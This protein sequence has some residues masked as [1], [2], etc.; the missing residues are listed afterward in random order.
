MFP[1]K[2]EELF[3]AAAEHQ[4]F[5]QAATTA[6]N[7]QQQG[8]DAVFAGSLSGPGFNAGQ[9]TLGTLVANYASQAQKSADLAQVLYQTGLAQ[10]DIEK[11]AEKV[12]Q[13]ARSLLSAALHR[14]TI[15]GDKAI[16]SLPICYQIL[17]FLHGISLILDKTCAHQIGCIAVE[18]DDPHGVYLGDDLS[19]TPEQLNAQAFEHIRP[20]VRPLV[21]DPHIAGQDDHTGRKK[22]QAIQVI[23]GKAA[24]IFGD[25]AQAK[26]IVTVVQGVTSSNPDTIVTNVANVSDFYE[27]LNRGKG[28][29]AVVMYDYAAPKGVPSGIHP[30]YAHKAA[31]DYQSYKKAL[32][33]KYPDA[34]LM[35]VG[36]SYGSVLL[37]TAAQRPGGLE[38]DVLIDA[39]SPG[40][41]TRSTR[42]LHLN[43]SNPEVISS[44]N[45][46]DPARMLHT[47]DLG[48]HGPDP[49]DKLFGATE[50]WTGTGGHDYLTNP[51]FRAHMRDKLATYHR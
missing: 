49:T 19:L 2:S 4:K 20:E 15:L 40:M 24:L 16:D 31:N 7:S 18:H 36:H 51:D 45:D 10:R 25:P 11:A 46:A 6:M 34:Q 50:V 29:V 22:P 42:N 38:T 28:D 23:N 26:T 3:A 9:R 39:G 44:L 47:P 17:M 21:D 13:G 35:D 14:G 30:G 41:N 43:S 8:W 12:R 48:V 33:A 37:G 27:D 1:L 32:R 5:A